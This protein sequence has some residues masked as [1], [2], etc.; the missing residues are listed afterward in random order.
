MKT[1]HN[2]FKLIALL[3]LAALFLMA[4]ERPLPGDYNGADP[5]VDTSIPDSGAYPTETEGLP[6]PLEVPLEAEAYPGALPEAAPLD[7][8][9]EGYPADAAQPAEVPAEPPAEAEAAAT[10]VV[11]EAPPADTAVPADAAAS[12]QPA[13]PE[14]APAVETAAP[15]ETPGTHTVAAGENLYRISLLYGISW[16]DLAAANGITNPDDLTIGQVLT[17]PTPGA[18]TAPA[19]TAEPAPADTAEAPPAT[20]EPAAEAADT[21]DLPTT[22]VVQ[23][24]DN[25]FRI[26]LNFGIDWNL[27]VAANGIIN[28]FIYPGQELIIPA[29][30]GSTAVDGEAEAA[31]AETAPVE[32]AATTEPVAPSGT[33]HVVQA[34]ETV[35]GIA[36]Q[37]GVTWTSLVQANS[38]PAPY[39]LEPGQVLV[40]PES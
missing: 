14:E 26:G 38:V 12:E 2:W 36:F 10:P 18:E 15:Q 24:G 22:Y 30:D 37:Y 17:I 19:D 31:P 33:T 34:G 35:F 4:C 16:T 7:A 21:A 25:L 6:S 39:T 9:V 28:N 13:A 29:A 1:R 8:A 23:A 32:D 27:I 20:E 40:I 11:E 3:A 5:E